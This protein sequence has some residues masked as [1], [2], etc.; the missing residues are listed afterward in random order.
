MKLA[1]I[2]HQRERDGRLVVVNREMTRCVP[3][4]DIALTMQAA[5]EDWKNIKHDLHRIYKALN[6]DNLLPDAINLRLEDV[7]APLP[8]SYQ[9]LDGSAY[10]HH[11][12]LTRRSRGAHMPELFWKEP[13][14]YQGCS[15][16]FLAW[17]ED[18]VAESKNFGVDFESEVAVILD[19]VQQGTGKPEAVEHIALLMLVNDVSLRHL[20]PHELSKGFGFVQS[21]PPCSC[22][23]IA[24]TPDELG[25]GW[26]NSKV[27]F[28]ICSYVNQQWV[29]SPNAGRDMV[30][31]FADLIVHASRTRSL[32]AGTII[33]SG[34]VSNKDSKTGSSCLVEKRMLEAQEFG[35]ARSSYL[36]NNDRVRIEMLDA[37][38]ASIFGS[39]DQKIKIEVA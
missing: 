7:M 31:D 27:H 12:E 39:I 36:L 8:R 17:N 13:L 28:S 4:P 1:T 5:L 20:I 9:W 38:A 22:S 16:R 23:P 15:D 25:A 14:M 34:T 21:K 2:R 29:G 18:I 37:E 19:D 6:Y 33:G 26:H 10:V 3:V 30:F 32:H 24:V 35:E 11:V